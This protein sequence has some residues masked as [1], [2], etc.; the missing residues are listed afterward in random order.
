MDLVVDVFYRG[1]DTKRPGH[2]CDC[3]ISYDALADA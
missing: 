3:L 1:T 2:P